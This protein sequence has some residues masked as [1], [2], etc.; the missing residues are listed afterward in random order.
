MDASEVLSID[1]LE[2]KFPLV[3]LRKQISSSFQLLNKTD[4][5]VAFKVKTTNPK[6]YSVR[7]N[8]GIVLPR[9]T[10]NVIVTMQAQK[11]A[12]PDMQCKDRFL[13]QS[14]VARPGATPKDINPEMFNKEVGN[15]VEE[16]KLRVVYVSPPKP[17]SPVPEESEEGASPRASESENG[18]FNTP[19]L[20]TVS[21]EHVE[22]QDNNTEARAIFLKLTEEKNRIL[23]QN[24]KLCQELGTSEAWTYKK[25]WRS[26][27]PVY[28]ACWLDWHSDG[29]FYEEIMIDPW[30]ISHS[31]VIMSHHKTQK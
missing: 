23:Q 10:C 31:V 1:P 7:P 29:V 5:H 6:K 15:H 4:K 16:F 3:E 11:E 17:P 18:H 14:V 27:S 25:Q 26:K 8:N 24:D 2:L 19:E 28:C 13:V 30:F 20:A 21:R 22:V 9:S 12:P